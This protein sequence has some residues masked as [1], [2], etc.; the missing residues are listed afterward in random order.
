MGLLILFAVLSIFFSFMCSI[1]EAALLSVTP[2]YIKIKN[3]EGKAYA[4]TL[5][6]FKQDIDKPLI[7]ILTVNT[8]SH[9]V[10]AIL[11]GVQAEKIYG[12]GG[13]AVGIV[14]AVM[15][16]AILILSEII[17][18]T[19]G[20]TYWQALG[21]FTAKALK[22]MIFPL[23]YTGILWLMMLTTKLIGKSA[24]VSSMNREEFA[25]IT[26]AAE[27]EGVFDESETT[28]IKN[29]LVF[30]SVKAKDVMTP[31]SVAIIENEDT[32]IEEFHRTHKNLK[33]SRIPVYKNQ[34]NNVTGFILKDDVLEEMIDDKGAE[35][36]STLKRDI[37]M[38]A[39]DTPIPELFE[40]F[41]QK[42][43]HI[44]M[45]VDEFGNTV[46][47]VTM[48]DIIETLLGLEIMDESDS[49][50]DM[51]MLARQNLEKRAK[52][53]GLIQRRDNEENE[54]EKSDI[55]ENSTG[56]SQN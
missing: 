25:A 42:R 18:K 10:G 3:K 28:V 9:T 50:E 49:I 27:E 15:T 29:L 32:S 55:S 33:F 22:I 6:N 16:V 31:Y 46:G 7:A 52:R 47:L 20:A 30:K 8:I 21:N 36:L 26:D 43:G 14:S 45:I 38:S 23:R 54:D 39:E 56:N 19:I 24:H 1:L 35:P 44:S 41:V 37:F 12:D 2:S 53:L 11:V 13:N 5:A 40:N 48:E 4:K 34:T 17:P 51:Q